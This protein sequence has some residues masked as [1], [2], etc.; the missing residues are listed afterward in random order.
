VQLVSISITRQADDESPRTDPRQA[1]REFRSGVREALR[2]AADG[3]GDEDRQ[4]IK[5]LL[6]QF[7]SAVRG[8]RRHGHHERHDDDHQV[9]RSE[10]TPTPARTDRSR[11]PLAGIET[12]LNR[13]ADGLEGLL[14]G[15]EAPSEKLAQVVSKLRT[16]M[17]DLAQALGLPVEAQN[18]EQDQA[19]EDSNDETAQ[20]EPCVS[21]EPPQHDE[22][23]VLPGGG[24]FSFS[25]QIVQVQAAYQSVQAL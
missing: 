22:Q 14:S 20:P 12:A 10:G 25:I 21:C 15:T 9:E 23:P 4:Q 24:N 6:Q 11:D 19:V 3:L 1:W 8:G 17:Q 16:L 5:E 2:E 13:L 18:V 7:G